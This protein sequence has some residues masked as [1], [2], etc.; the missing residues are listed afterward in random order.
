MK[1]VELE[2]KIQRVK[3][4]ISGLYNGTSGEEFYSLME[5]DIPE[6]LEEMQKWRAFAVKLNKEN[7]KLRA[8]LANF[9][10]T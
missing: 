9:G 3:T 7:A 1:Q 6:I 5:E 8:K 4:H 10:I 2:Q